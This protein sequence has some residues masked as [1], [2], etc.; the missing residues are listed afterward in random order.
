MVRCLQMSKMFTELCSKFS[1][2]AEAYDLAVRQ[3]DVL[4]R[5]KLCRAEKMMVKESVGDIRKTVLLTNTGAL[6]KRYLSPTSYTR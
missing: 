4:Y 5:L 1:T 6:M 2:L 3:K